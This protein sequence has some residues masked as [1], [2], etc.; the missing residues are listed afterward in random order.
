M[1]DWLRLYRYTRCLR[2]VRYWNPKLADEMAEKA[3]RK[4]G[5]LIIS[6]EC[7]NCGGWHI[8]HA[9]QTQLAARNLKFG[10]PLPLCSICGKVIPPHRLAKAARWGTATTTCSR[11][12]TAEVRRR[13][14][15]AKN[16]P[17]APV[18]EGS[19]PDES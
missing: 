14:K 16:P 5:E 1:T 11:P 17:P 6:Y 8:G 10:D 7:L 19:A 4:T 3:S 2:K 12:C 18:S 13:R 9:D 15:Q